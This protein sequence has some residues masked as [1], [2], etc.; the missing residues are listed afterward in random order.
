MLIRAGAEGIGEFGV[1][2]SFFR[3]KVFGFTCG[4][5][6]AFGTYFPTGF[7]GFGKSI[8]FNQG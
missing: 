8:I 5:S 6:M 7:R 3:W 4:K 2:R 1:S